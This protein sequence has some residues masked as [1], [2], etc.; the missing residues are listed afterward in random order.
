MRLWQS[1]VKMLENPDP[2]ERAY[3]ALLIG[4]DGWNDEPV[5]ERLRKMLESDSDVLCRACAGLALVN[6]GKLSRA[7]LEAIT[8][9]QLD[10][11]QERFER[12]TERIAAALAPQ[13]EYYAEP[14]ALAW[15]ELTEEDRKFAVQG[16]PP[17]APCMRRGMAIYRRGPEKPAAY[18]VDY[19][20]AI[21]GSAADLPGLKLDLRHQDMNV[22]YAAIEVLERMAPSREAAEV[23]LGALEADQEYSVKESAIHALVKFKD[24]GDLIVPHLDRVMKGKNKAKVKEAAGKLR[25][26]L[27]AADAPE[28][29]LGAIIADLRSANEEARRIAA[30]EL[31]RMGPGGAAAIPQLIALLKDKSKGVRHASAGALGDI[32]PA[33]APAVPALIPML[34][35]RGKGSVRGSVAR[36]IGRIGPAAASSIPALLVM[37][38]AEDQEL[39]LEIAAEALVKV[40]H[41]RGEVFRELAPK[42]EQLFVRSQASATMPLKALRDDC[43]VPDLAWHFALKLLRAARKSPANLPLREALIDIIGAAGPLAKEAHGDLAKIAKESSVALPVAAARAIFKVAGGPDEAAYPA[44]INCFR[45]PDWLTYPTYYFDRAHAE[46]AGL[47]AQ[48]P[49]HADEIVPL[50]EAHL[51]RALEQG[52]REIAVSA[53]RGAIE[54][55]GGAA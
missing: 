1:L 8:S 27:G 37:L 3:S 29:P 48:M 25:V 36:A 10:I 9:L 50:F 53:L 45:R 33:A 31:Q 44:L 42:I 32:G 19:T 51:A 15:E 12:V 38:R 49:A 39:E 46:L 23:L 52:D 43:D 14:L 5:V 35:D 18:Q 20:K 16:G 6:L 30:R 24:H 34:E 4:K 40:G 2:D 7:E 54:K 22:R 26:T 13:K 55:L 11:P 17:N 41:D 28:G 47:L 21:P